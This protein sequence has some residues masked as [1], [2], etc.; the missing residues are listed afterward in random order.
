[1]ETDEIKNNLDFLGLPY[2]REE[3]HKTSASEAV[4]PL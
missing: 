2:L 4:R 1:M 3:Y